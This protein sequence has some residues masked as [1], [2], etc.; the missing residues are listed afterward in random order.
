MV[1]FSLDGVLLVLNQETVGG[2]LRWCPLG[3]TYVAER[4]GI[5]VTFSLGEPPSVCHRHSLQLVYRGRKVTFKQPTL[6]RDKE[7]HV[8]FESLCDTIAGHT[9]AEDMPEAKGAEQQ[10]IINTLMSRPGEIVHT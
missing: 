6:E 4:N 10:R 9:D 3:E 1:R 8:A 2:V 7:T 5:L